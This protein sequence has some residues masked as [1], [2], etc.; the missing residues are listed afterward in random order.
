[1]DVWCEI[2]GHKWDSRDPGVR[3]LYGGGC[4]ECFDEAQCFARRNIG[5]ALE[6]AASSLRVVKP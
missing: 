3:Y 6:Q 5:I 4:W 2:C 1:M